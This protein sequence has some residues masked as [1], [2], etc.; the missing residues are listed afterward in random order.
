MSKTHFGLI[1]VVSFEDDDIAQLHGRLIEK[2][3]PGLEVT[4]RCIEDQPRGIYD[5]ET[6]A[7][8]VPK[9]VRLGA[10]FAEEG[11]VAGLIISCAADPAVKELRETV[12]IPVIGA[13]SAAAALALTF[14]DRV[15]T[16]GITE[17][18]PAAMQAVLGSRLV[19]EAKPQG[20]VNTLDLM[21]DEGRNSALAA[22]SGLRE[23]GA[24]VI[25]LACTGYATIGIAEELEKRAGI[26]VV[27]AVLAAGLAAWFLSR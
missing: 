18:T 23:Q 27:D 16:L 4:S 12:K 3:Y 17:D 1:R 15:G 8:A 5:D 2:T 21:N 11:R 25:A 13:G 7:L 19:A 14:G 20:V 26:P 10:Q 22:V 24:E 6:E 9:I